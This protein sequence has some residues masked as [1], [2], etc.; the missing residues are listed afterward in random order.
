MLAGL[1][2][3][4]FGFTQFLYVLIFGL[5][6]LV[7]I[8]TIST[9]VR[10]NYFVESLSSAKTSEKIIAITFDDGPS[11]HTLEILKI[12]EKYQAKAAF[13]CIG[14]NIEKHPEIFKKI[15]ENGH[16]VGNHTYSHTRKMGALN[17]KTT[18]RE[19]ERCNQVAEKTAGVKMKLFRPPFGIVSPHTRDALKA[20]GMLS[21]GWSIRSFDAI[22][23][24]EE[25]VLHRVKKRVKPG[26]I[27]LFHD[28]L[29]Q[30]IT[31]LEQ[32][33][34]FLRQEEYRVERPDKL[35]KINAYT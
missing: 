11:E 34:L 4:S 18:T 35:L 12:L 15:I 23:P 9:N 17:T 8:L 32:L 3:V 30:S 7:F 20:T 6:Y 16:I 33:L 21:V 14:R 24:S 27:I 25:A 10:L 2:W 31:I 29:P 19:I 5:L 13:F 1:V 22:I 26:G 28:N